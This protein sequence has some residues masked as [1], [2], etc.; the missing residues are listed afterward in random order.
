MRFST[1]RPGNC[2]ILLVLLCASAATIGCDNGS[3][4]LWRSYSSRFID[5]DGR[6]FDPSGDQ[7]T[8]SEAQAYSLFFALAAN[9]TQTFHRVLDW[10]EANLAQNDL[11]TH[12]PAQLYGKNKTGQWAILDPNS[13]SNADTWIAYSLLEA[14]RLWNSSAYVSLGRTM[15]ELIAKNEVA[16]LPGF[17]PMLLPGPSGYQH[18]N[19]I[20]LNPSYL[21]LFLFERFA[22]VDPSG[23]WQQIAR[24]I[25]RLLQQGSRHGFAMD[26][27]EYV[28]GDGFYPTTDPLA[29]DQP[30][31]SANT[32]RGSGDAI[33]VYLWAG[34][35]NRDDPQR[36]AVLNADPGMS[37]YL[38]THDAPPEVINEEGI[39]EPQ[40]GP[41]G[42][43]AVMLEYLRAF[44]HLSRATARQLIRLTEEKQVETGLYGRDNSYSDQCLALFA[45]GFFDGRFRVG[46][47][48]ELNVKWKR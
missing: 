26:W 48:G 20:T 1:S 10:T 7:H 18:G 33:C 45:T 22:A 37:A 12:L 27:V 42:Y 32:P 5:A 43:S 30:G 3:W 13:A 21:P 23:P 4:P 34:M 29:P 16:N 39:P 15:L 8:T 2:L 17:G 24:N 47:R 35:L 31:S 38:E 6:V 44:P 41:V 36:A 28:S 11:R 25:P 9:D 14:G 19:T 40:N 46:M